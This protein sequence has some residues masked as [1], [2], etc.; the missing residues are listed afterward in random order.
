MSE[1]NHFGGPSHG[2]G[3]CGQK[4]EQ[5]DSNLVEPFTWNG[6]RQIGSFECNQDFIHHMLE[7]FNGQLRKV[8]VY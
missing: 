5:F 8:E 7:K 4:L 1:Y 6:I 2:S 3:C